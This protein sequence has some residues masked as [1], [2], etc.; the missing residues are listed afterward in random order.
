MGLKKKKSRNF[1]VNNYENWENGGGKAKVL[2]LPLD[3]WKA[4]GEQQSSE[5]L[6]VH[7]FLMQS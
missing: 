4:N 2:S 3:T 1:W 5:Y 7:S 6:C